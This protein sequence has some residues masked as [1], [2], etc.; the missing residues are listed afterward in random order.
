MKPNN[1]NTEDLAII[2][3]VLL[4]RNFYLKDNNPSYV[5]S[6]TTEIHFLNTEF[7]NKELFYRVP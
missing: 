3:S 5:L 1:C 2:L 4:F 6:F 7:A